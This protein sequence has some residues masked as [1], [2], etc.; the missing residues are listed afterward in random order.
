MEQAPVGTLVGTDY[1]GNR[2]YE[3][4]NG[5]YSAFKEGLGGLCAAWGFARTRTLVGI[6][7]AAAFARC[8]VVLPAC[9]FARS[10]SLTTQ[11]DTNTNNE[12][13]ILPDRKRWVVYAERR[14]NAYSA[15]TIPPEWHAW[16]NYV[17]DFP[18]TEVRFHV[19][20]LE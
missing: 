5:T 3:N 9:R 4:K 1:N 15:T 10:H 16:V 18:P 7:A 11:H 8:C 13:P 19:L 6:A 20:V 14:T 17:N 12:T 2:Y